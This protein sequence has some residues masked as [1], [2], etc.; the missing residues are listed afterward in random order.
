METDRLCP[1]GAADERVEMNLKTGS[2]P[3]GPVAKTLWS[4]FRVSSFHPW[5]GN[6]IPQAAIKHSHAS[7][8][9]KVFKCPTKI[10]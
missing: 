5:S 6:H 2:L 1:R 9:L 10:R 3:D 8:N 7:G 4:Q